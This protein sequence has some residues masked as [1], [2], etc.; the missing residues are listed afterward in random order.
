M[1][2]SQLITACKNGD[3]AAQKQLYENYKSKMM[4]V[5]LRYAQ[6]RTEA[7][8]I[9]QEGF[10]QIFR[11]IHQYQPIGPF[12]G[13]MRRVIVNTALKHIRREK[14][15][16]FTHIDT[17]EIED[18]YQTN[19]NIFSTFRE[20]ALL[21][22]VQQLPDGYRMVFNLYVI[23]GYSHKEIAEQLEISQSTSKT[24]LRKAKIAL[25]KMIEK[26]I[27]I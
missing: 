3:P 27:H 19:E 5:C 14:R 15:N 11:D 18:S 25:R 8:D 6:T 7:H 17:S 2:E 26:E 10:I 12:G 24:Q 4:G 20:K 22:M 16:L 23:E 9:F 13:W 21:K 1:T